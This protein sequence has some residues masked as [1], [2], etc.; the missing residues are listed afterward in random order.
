MKKQKI[1]IQITNPK[2]PLVLYLLD[3]NFIKLKLNKVF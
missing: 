3:L 1:Q 2:D